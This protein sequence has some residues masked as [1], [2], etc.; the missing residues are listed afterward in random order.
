MSSIILNVQKFLYDL[1]SDIDI[2]KQ[3]D[4]EAQNLVYYPCARILVENVK[5]I[6]CNVNLKVIDIHIDIFF[7]NQNQLRDVDQQID[8]KIHNIVNTRCFNSHVTNV[9]FICSGFS[10]LDNLM[11]KRLRLSYK[12]FLL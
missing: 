8:T 3:I 12:L 9:A 6:L 11:T 2:L 10:Q 7:D 4:T 5:N 1:L